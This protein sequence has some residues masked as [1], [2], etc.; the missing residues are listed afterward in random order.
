[1][2]PLSQGSRKVTI[3]LSRQSKKSRDPVFSQVKKSRNPVFLAGQK[4]H[5]DIRIHFRDISVHLGI[6]GTLLG[7]HIIGQVEHIITLGRVPNRLNT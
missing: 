4:L 7:K 2:T 1:M 3:P 6:L 5:R